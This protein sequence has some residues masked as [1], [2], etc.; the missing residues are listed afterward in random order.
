ERV[1]AFRRE[2]LAHRIR[3]LEALQA[4]A[5]PEAV[6][7]RFAPADL[8]RVAREHRLAP[9]PGAAPAPGGAGGLAAA[10]NRPP[11]PLGGAEGGGAAPGAPGGGPLPTSTAGDPPIQVRTPASRRAQEVLGRPGGRCLTADR[12]SRR[13]GL[14]ERLWQSAARDAA[15]PPLTPESTGT[16]V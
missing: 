3:Q 13:R 8:L 9:A 10:P 11:P 6:G 15:C 4:G 1:N 12:R 7:P 2:V 5:A 16:R 14:A